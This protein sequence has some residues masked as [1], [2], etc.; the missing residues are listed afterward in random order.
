MLLYFLFFSFF[1]SIHSSQQPLRGRPSNV[2]Q[3]FRPRWS[4]INWPRDLAHTSANFYR[5]R[6]SKS[7]KFGLIFD[8]TRLWATGIWKCNKISELW[9]KL[10]E[11]R[12]SPC[13]LTKFGE[14]QFMQPW[15]PSGESAPPPKIGWRKCA[16]S[17][18]TQTR[19]TQFLS[20]FVESLYMRSPRDHTSWR[21]K[22]Q[23]SRSQSDVMGVNVV[24]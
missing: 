15:E 17:S 20:N 16:K 24:R 11:L 2:L 23:R 9:N 19:V 1:V 14:V 7:A 12:W 13:V 18:I 10:G 3:T 21:S 8:M 4:F 6:G 22:G 5:G